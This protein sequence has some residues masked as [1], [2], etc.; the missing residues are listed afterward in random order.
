MAS[1]SLARCLANVI[2]GLSSLVS[3]DGLACLVDMRVERADS[4]L[5]ACSIGDSSRFRFP[6]TGV[7]RAAGAAKSRLASVAGVSW[8]DPDGPGSA[9]PCCGTAGSVKLES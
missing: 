4:V 5:P 9:D 3:F 6:P 2:V 1:S 8:V 7:L